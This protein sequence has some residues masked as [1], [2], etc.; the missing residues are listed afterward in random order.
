M[1]VLNQA[2]GL[3]LEMRLRCYVHGGGPDKNWFSN[4]SCTLCTALVAFAVKGTLNVAFIWSPLKV[5]RLK[6][7][8]DQ[9]TIYKHETL[10][11]VTRNV[12]R[13]NNIS[14]NCA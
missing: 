9:R 11:F 13:R 10:S 1:N 2:L 5:A 14:N 6:K 4:F 8:V 12:S 7:L 3:R